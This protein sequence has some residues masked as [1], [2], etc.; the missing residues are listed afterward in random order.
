MNDVVRG[1]N[2]FFVSV[3]PKLSDEIKGRGEFIIIMEI[4]IQTL[5]FKEQRK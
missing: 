2:K 4:E 3:G 5:Y 1:F